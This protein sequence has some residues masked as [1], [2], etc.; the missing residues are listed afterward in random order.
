MLSADCH[1]VAE[2]AL[3]HLMAPLE[4]LLADPGI[5]E[6][7]VNSPVATWFEQ[8]G[9]LVQSAAQVGRAE[10]CAMGR[11][12]ATLSNSDS[13]EQECVLEGRW[14]EWRV[15]LVLPPV[16]G[17]HPTLALRRHRTAALPLEA[18]GLGAPAGALEQLRAA[19]VR[20]DNILVAGATG[21]G[22][23][24]LL[25]SLLAELGAGERLV[26]L[27][28][29]P[30][31]PLLGAHQLRLQTRAGHSLR[32]LVRVALRLRPDRLVIGE[33]RGGEAFDLLQAMATGHR[34]CLGTLHAADPRAAL[35]RFEQLILTS[36]LDWPIAAVREQIAHTVQLLV[37]VQRGPQGRAIAGIARLQGLAQGDYVLSAGA[38]MHPNLHGMPFASCAP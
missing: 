18:W 1:A 6:I 34:G 36:G 21:A 30:E 17:E 12:F 32:S 8:G 7:L 24:T 23:T 15:T 26:C 27:E 37:Q 38:N 14:R 29:T 5:S 20:Q 10:L 2:A 4:A 11:L 28:D 9:Q 13:L 16:S 3:A 31:L 19:L 22:K 35:A 25:A 33:V